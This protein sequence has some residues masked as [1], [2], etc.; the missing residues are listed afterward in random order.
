MATVYLAPTPLM[1][2]NFNPF[3]LDY[4]L[5]YF[6]YYRYLVQ[7]G[8]GPPAVRWVSYRPI[9][10]SF[11]GDNVFIR[12]YAVQDPKGFRQV[13]RRGNYSEYVAY[14]INKMLRKPLG[15]Q[16]E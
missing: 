6:R 5:T 4:R 16:A 15:S 1:D 9:V 3:R 13:L 7:L 12:S 10:A 8:G 2:F 11:A 14:F